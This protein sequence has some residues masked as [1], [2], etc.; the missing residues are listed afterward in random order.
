MAKFLKHYRM[1]MKQFNIQDDSPFL[2]P[3]LSLLQTIA[4]F[5]VGLE[6]CDSLVGT[7]VRN[8]ARKLDESATG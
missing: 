6:D 2:H 1:V 5:L 3:A 8:S 7:H 4:E